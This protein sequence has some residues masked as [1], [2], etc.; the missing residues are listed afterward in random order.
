MIFQ[1]K[2]LV[3][4]LT[5]HITNCE[6]TN[7]YVHYVKKIHT[8]LIQNIVIKCQG[9]ISTLL[10]HFRHIITEI[11]ARFITF[12]TLVLLFMPVL[13]LSNGNFYVSF[14]SSIMIIANLHGLINTNNLPQTQINCHNFTVSNHYSL[15]KQWR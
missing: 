2:W 6:S 3:C 12:L 15:Q 5:L 8:T 10:F 11:F 9:N 7:C 14:S 13:C 4:I 1:E